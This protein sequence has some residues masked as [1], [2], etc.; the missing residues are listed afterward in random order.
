M[1]HDREAVFLQDNGELLIGYFDLLHEGVRGCEVCV[2][3]DNDPLKA[4]YIPYVDLKG[5]GYLG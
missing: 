2:L 1:R 5:W 4:H 3:E